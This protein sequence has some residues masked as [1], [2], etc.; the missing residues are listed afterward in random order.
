MHEIIE[1]EATQ[2]QT[3]GQQVV[4]A[5]Y[6]TA[7]QIIKPRQL[8][9][10]TNRVLEEASIAGDEFYYSWR[11]GGST[12]EGLTVGA[13]MAIARNLG[14][15]AIP[16]EVEDT[17]DAYIFKATFIDLETG[18][19]LQ[20]TFR[21]RKAQNMGA[22]M[23]NDGRAEDVIFQIGQ[24][25]AIR[26][27]VLASVPNWLSKKVL[28]K[29]KENVKGKIEQMGKERAREMLE[30]KAK[31]LEIPLEKIE[32]NF[33]RSASWDTEQLVLISGA[34]RSV[35]DGHA[36]ID[37]AFPSEKIDKL[38]EKIK[39][40][41]PKPTTPHDP[42]TGEVKDELPPYAEL[43]A[44]FKKEMLARGVA[45]QV[46]GNTVGKYS[47]EQLRDLLADLGSLD[48]IA[49]DLKPSTDEEIQL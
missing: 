33:G 35:E 4:S 17:K 20:R 42:N 2:A 13:S 11:Q 8:Q 23:K 14:N 28:E 48:A 27:V 40:T 45:D 49:E 12:I 16:V 32:E 1:V 6:T 5:N 26:N 30:R 41:E 3:T 10:V 47:R 29:A 34:I 39:N 31:N 38:E 36:S 18:F 15:C 19:N 9:A 44:Q 7:M 37:D 24:S 46:I 43:S 21:Q 22:K 25:K